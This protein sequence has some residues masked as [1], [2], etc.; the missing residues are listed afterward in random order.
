MYADLQQKTELLH[1]IFGAEWTPEQQDGQKFAY[2]NNPNGTI[3]WIF[4]A[5]QKWPIYLSLYNSAHFK[6]QVYKFLSKLSYGLGQG[7]RLW[8]GQFRIPADLSSALLNELDRLQPDA[9]AIFTGT[10]G[11]NRKSVLC[12]SNQK[13]LSQFM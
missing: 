4:P 13:Q 10:P 5:D 2:I 12:L 3:R 7:K 8:S 11:E 6:A 1:K 9:Y